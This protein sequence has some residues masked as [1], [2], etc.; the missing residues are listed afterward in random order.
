[1]PSSTSSFERIAGGM[2]WRT[3]LGCALLA[4]ASFAFLLE[5]RLE[6]Q[7]FAATIADSQ[8]RWIQQR[9]RAS[10][11]GSR[12]LIM[13]GASRI[14]L[15][16]SIDTLRRASGLEP[17]QLAIDGA[18]FIPVL[19]GLAADPSIKGTVLIDFYNFVPAA[20]SQVGAR[21]EAAY[22]AI[23]SRGSESPYAR[24]EAGLS[25]QLHTSLR[26]YSDGAS[27][28]NALLLRAL[29]SE[30]TRNYLITFPD[31]SRAADYA[32]VNMPDFYYARVARELG[33]VPTPGQ[34]LEMLRREIAHL[35]PGDAQSFMATTRAIKQMIARIEARGGSVMVVAM[36]TSA[37]VKEIEERR[38]PRQL[39]WDRFVQEL[40]VRA[41]RADE[42]EELRGLVCPD[43]S[44][45]DMRD[46]E[47]VTTAIAHA[48]FHNPALPTSKTVV[49]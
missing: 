16:L 33:L 17:V 37:M 32:Q 41:V 9:Q 23:A 28:L 40:G 43:G 45:V 13:I 30:P 29:D 27:P 22:A 4:W 14:Q 25:E 18:S 24:V 15:G 44:H 8:Q 21:Y 34:G 1:M 42:L 35:G 39:F 10:A 36:P 3:I 19:A 2:D 26:T 38:F 6:Q 11:L 47:R 31:R 7:G 5:L 49:R 20:P 46:R 48:L 12:A